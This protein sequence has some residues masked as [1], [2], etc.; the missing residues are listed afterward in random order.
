MQRGEA[1]LLNEKT[2]KDATAEKERDPVSQYLARGVGKKRLRN[3]EGALGEE[4]SVGHTLTQRKIKRYHTKNQRSRRAW[5]EDD[6]RSASRGDDGGYR[7]SHERTNPTK[8]TE[9]GGGNCKKRLAARGIGSRFT[10]KK[11]C[12][13]NAV[14]AGYLQ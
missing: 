3:N 1:A 10:S 2:S 9:I 11:N 4:S 7:K 6:Q 13:A 12:T 14:E 8:K 5:K